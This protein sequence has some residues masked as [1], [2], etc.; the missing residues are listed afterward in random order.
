MGLDTVIGGITGGLGGLFGGA[1]SDATKKAANKAND[2]QQAAT[3]AQ[4]QLGRESLALN[5]DIYNS[6]YG[7]LSPFVSRGNVAGDSINAL[8]GLPSA[9]AMT[10]PLATSGTGGTNGSS[11]GGYTGPNLSQIVAMK[12]DHTKGNMTSAVNQFLS[13]YQAHPNEDPGITPALIAGLKGD[14]I[15]GD[16]EAIQGLYNTWQ[17][18]PAQTTN[19]GSAPGPAPVG[20]STTPATTPITAQNAFNNFANSAGMQFQLQQ[21]ENAINNG[22]AARGQLQSGAALKGL[23]DYGQKTALNNYFLPYLGLLGGQQATGV[24]AASSIAGVGANFGNTAANINAGMGQNIQSGANAASNAAL[25][26]GQANA[27]M[28]S[29]IASGIGNFA[30][31]FG[32]F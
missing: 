22:Y 8:L 24:G 31:S 32:G 26:K 10:S 3:Q 16:Q 2:A 17:S 15:P 28:W 14:H 19:Q 18:H 20:G 12:G 6:N 23:Q 30:S 11:S 21:G 27:N 7:I 4:L 25:L 5:K 29:G 9:P 1:G 13:Y